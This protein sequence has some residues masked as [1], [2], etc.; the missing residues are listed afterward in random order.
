MLRSIVP[1]IKSLGPPED[2]AIFPGKAGLSNLKPAGPTCRTICGRR[3]RLPSPPQRHRESDD[4]RDDPAGRSDACPFNEHFRCVGIVG[5]PPPEEGRRQIDGDARCELKP[6]VSELRLIAEPPGRPLRRGPHRD[7]HDG[8]DAGDLAPKYSGCGHG[9]EY[10]ATPQS[11]DKP[12]CRLRVF[13]DIRSN[14]LVRQT[15]GQP[16]SGALH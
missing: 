14:R 11:A 2:H 15:R 3:L 4:N 5:I 8:Q 10:R 7:E 13:S 9:I 12:S 1:Q 16:R 6:G